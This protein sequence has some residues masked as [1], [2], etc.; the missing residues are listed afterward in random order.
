[1]G[2]PAWLGALGQAAA[3][4]GAA[5]GE[6]VVRRETHISRVFLVGDTAWKLKKPVDYGFLDF[7]TPERRRAACEAEVRLNAR[8]SP[9]VYLGVEAVYRAPDG[10][11]R[12]GPPG[13]GDEVLEPV[14]RMRRLPDAWRADTRLAAGDLDFDAVERIA[15]RVAAFHAACRRDAETDRYGT[16]EAIGANV[17]ENLVQSREILGRVLDLDAAEEVEAGQIRFLESEGARLQARIAAGRVRD[18]HGDLRLEHVYLR[19]DGG[20]TVID[21]IEFN[22]RFRYADVAADLA[23][24]A[25]DLTAKGRAD[26]AEHLLGSYAMAAND[27]ELFGVVDFYE[28]YRAWVRAKVAGFLAADPAALP[29][30]RE[31]AREEARRYF[32]VALGT[33]R[34]RVLPPMVVA[35]GGPVAGGKSTL[36]REVSRWLAAPIVEADRT[37]K[38][39]VGVAATTRLNEGTWS[40]AYDPGFTERVYAELVRRGAQVVASGRPVVLDAS[41]RAARFRA[42][43]RRMAE[44]AGVPFRFLECTAPRDVLAARLVEREQ[45]PA[46]VSDA[47]VGMLDDFLRAWEPVDELGPAVHRRLDTNRPL[48]ETL[49]EARAALPH[50]PP[51]LT[52]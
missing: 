45:D 44:V 32:L 12:V 5:P 27:Y 37:R 40:G 15:A 26:L 20:V 18:G 8:F 47:R 17:R 34:T 23:F 24:L 39:M 11:I 52:G 10:S 6:P 22:E 7:T 42:L 4:D 19:P 46:R 49:A 43:A 1:M 35:L 16:V 9:E 50:W 21:C 41:F 33:G 38:W 31:H 2:A 36:A 25:M 13:P 48:A 51:A 29:A 14:V 28:G 30:L 3:F